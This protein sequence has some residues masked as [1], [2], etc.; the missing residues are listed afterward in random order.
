MSRPGI[1]KEDEKSISKAWLHP[2]VITMLFLGFSAGIPILLIFSTL[3]AW[4][5]EAGVSKSSVTFFSWAALGYSFKF[6]WAPLVDT[7]PLPY[8][9]KIMGRRRSW[10]IISQIS[11]IIAIFWMGL[12]DPLQDANGLQIMA[13]AAVLLGFSSATQDIVIDAYRIECAAKSMQALL[14]S[15]YIAGYRIGMLV[16]GAGALYLADLLGTT[17]EVYKYSSWMYTYFAVAAMMLIGITTTLLMPEP[18]R[19]NNSNNIPKPTV[20]HIRLVSMFLLSVTGFCLTFFYAGITINLSAIIPGLNGPLTIFIHELLR[21]MAALGAALLT[22][23]VTVAIGIADKK[24]LYETFFAPVEDFFK[25]FGIKSALLILLLI[26]F[27]R[28]SDIVLGII[29][30]VFYL[31]MGFSKATIAGIAKSFGLIMTLAGG[32][33]GGMAAIRFGVIRVL[34]WGALLSALTNLLFMTLARSGPDL[35]IL[36]MVIS[37]D[38]LSAGLATTAFVAFLS[39]LTDIKFTA[40]QYALFSSLMTLFP[41]VL[42]GYSGTFVTAMG[43]EKFFLFTAI[44]GVPVLA[45]VLIAGKLL[46]QDNNQ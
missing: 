1:N 37:I 6:I 27:Y 17:K 34:F 8:L 14:S 41:K 39:S 2:Q 15:S 5:S 11:I 4:L 3:S 31:D 38:N 40:V 22:A 9:T 42:G 45:L 43:Y 35:T 20:Y 12:T 23:A 46:P 32:F 33:L 16:A 10:L 28:I 25:R 24:M 13:M 18:K 36:T 44:L 19:G 21:L 7:L 30:N 26:G 29:S